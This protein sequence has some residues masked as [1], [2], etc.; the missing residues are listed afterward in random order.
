MKKFSIL[1]ILS[2]F[3]V[4]TACDLFP[5]WKSYVEYSDTY[6][7]SGN[8]YV[9]DFDFDTDTV[10]TKWYN[11]YIYNK[12][13]NPTK[14]SIWI[15]NRIGH[16]TTGADIYD[17]LFKIKT[18]ADLSNLSFDCT[19]A[20]DVS[21]NNVNPLDSAVTVTVSNSK[22]FDMSDD[23]EDATPDSIYFEFT[24]YDKF[25]NVVRT[26]KTAGH[27][28]TGWENPFSDNM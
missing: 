28:K 11:L 17:F 12:S 3:S 27:R 22:V 2:V 19:L 18:K 14:D 9:R 16:S 26:L 6:P 24:Y 25:G 7:V 21:G 13:Y 4:L 15:D 10:V 20:G 5:D 1:F 23:I 8:Y